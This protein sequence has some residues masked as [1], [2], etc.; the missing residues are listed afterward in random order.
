MVQCETH[1]VEQI[2]NTLW[3]HLA[4]GVAVL[5]GNK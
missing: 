5:S 2:K 1:Q 3:N 4:L